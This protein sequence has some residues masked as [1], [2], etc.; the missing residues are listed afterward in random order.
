MPRCGELNEL[1]T[2][3][4]TAII[5]IGFVI[6]SMPVEHSG[7]QVSFSPDLPCLHIRD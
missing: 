7:I 6:S 3:Y 5:R 1:S 2:H 4:L